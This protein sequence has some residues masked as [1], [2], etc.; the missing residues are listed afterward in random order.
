MQRA[1]KDRVATV[2]RSDSSIADIFEAELES[3]PMAEKFNKTTFIGDIWTVI[4]AC[5]NTLNNFVKF[6]RTSSCSMGTNILLCQFNPQKSSHLEAF[7]YYF[8]RA[9]G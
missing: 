1:T 7:Y 5:P 4:F 3:N 8:C 9:P 6:C 2:F